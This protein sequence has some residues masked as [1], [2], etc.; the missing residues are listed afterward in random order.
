MRAKCTDV[1]RWP[2]A[3]GARRHQNCA[4]DPSGLPLRP[5][6]LWSV[7]DVLSIAGNLTGSSISDFDLPS[8]QHQV[9]RERE[10]EPEPECKALPTVP[11]RAGSTPRLHSTLGGREEGLKPAFFSNEGS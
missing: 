3:K 4:A 6:I 7:D 1:F 10:F 5:V 9:V 2:G 11:G 8:H